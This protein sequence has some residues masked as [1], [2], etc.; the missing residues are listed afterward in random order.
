MRAGQGALQA[1][2][3]VADQLR[4]DLVLHG[5]IG[6]LRTLDIHI[7]GIPIDCRLG[8]AAELEVGLTNAIRAPE[9][10]PLRGS[11]GESLPQ[12]TPGHRVLHGVLKVEIA[13][14]VVRGIRIG[15]VRRKD[16]MALAAQ[17][18]GLAKDGKMLAEVHDRCFPKTAACFKASFVPMIVRDAGTGFGQNAGMSFKALIT[19][20]LLLLSSLIPLGQVSAADAQIVMDTA[21]QHIRLQTQALRGQVSITM[22]PL[23]LAKLPA[24][25]AHQAFTPQGSRMMGKTTV[26]V[27]CLSPQ[28]WSVLV[29][30]QIAVTGNYVTAS[31]PLVAGQT[32]QASD[33]NTLSGDLSQLPAGIVED[34]NQAV[35]KTLRQSLG[36]GQPIRGD[37]LI[38]PQVIRQGQTVRVTSRGSGFAVTGEG[39]ALGNAAVGQMVQIRM[40]SGQTISGIAQ[41]DGNVEVQF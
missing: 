28:S 19:A 39:K 1:T 25:S 31:R 10:P 14:L 21:E 17:V 35:G 30:A 18:H 4:Q 26:G 2:E 3:P 6:D 33:L 37:Q 5:V 34:L 16:L 9:M 20:A 12:A 11:H 38:A 27:R 24:C 23:D 32:L 15:D 13:G 7:H 22:L 36:A 41:P 29:P 40:N 8:L